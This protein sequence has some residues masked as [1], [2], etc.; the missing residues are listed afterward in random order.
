MAGQAPQPQYYLLRPPP[1]KGIPVGL[2]IVLAAVVVVAFVGLVYVGYVLLAGPV[3][4][5]ATP[6]TNVT[7]SGIVTAGENAA[8]PVPAAVVHIAVTSD[9]GGG[10]ALSVIADASGAYEFEARAG[11]TYDLYAALGI[12]WGTA[13]GSTVTRTIAGTTPA[14]SVD[15]TV[16]A[17][18]IYGTVTNASSG[19]PIGGAALGVTDPS[20]S[21]WCCQIS[22]PDGTYLLWGISTGFYTV[23]ATAAGYTASSAHPYVSSMYSSSRADLPLTPAAG[24]APPVDVTVRGIVTAGQNASVPVPNA[25]VHVAVVSGSSGSV[26]S[27]IQTD[28]NGAYQFTATSG[29]TYSLY[30][31]LG[32]AFGTATGSTTTRTI[33]GTA[34]VVS[35]NL[36][37]PASDIYGV[38]TN[39]TTGA[40]IGGATIGLTPPSG[41]SWCC[42]VTGSNGEYLLWEISTGSYT[43]SV[44]AAGYA[45]AS[46]PVN[47]A[48]M[49][50]S[51]RVDFPL[52][53]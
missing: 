33:S 11:S 41:P 44:Q 36:T 24:G 7:V 35:V 40:P 42:Q 10:G 48:A 5:G 8:V 25:L 50:T 22:G 15:L 52:R 46:A 1:R 6:F 49:Y 29:A 47:V 23:S 30:A 53:P 28:S 45:G 37:V 4:R 27:T 19:L 12:H 13:T 14:V 31:T 51:S 39:A 32:I 38:I 43:V 17:S 20:G 3:P 18:D 16:P 26:P 9:S 21:P 34:P 2:V